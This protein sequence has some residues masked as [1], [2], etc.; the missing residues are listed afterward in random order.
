MATEAGVDVIDTAISSL[1]SLTSQPSMNSV[2]AALEG[3]ERETGLDLMELQKLTD[4][5]D[6]IRLIITVSKRGSSILQ[7]I[8]TAMKFPVDN[9]LI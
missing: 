8:F 3:Q 4:Y 6:D 9:I 1:S 2:V 7:R 5:W